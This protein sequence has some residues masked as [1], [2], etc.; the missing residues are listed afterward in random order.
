MRPGVAHLPIVGV[1]GSHGHDWKAYAAPLG[2]HLAARGVHLLTGGG[3]GTM[4][5][6][7]EAFCAVPDRRG[8]S[9]GILPAVPDRERGFAPMEGYPNPW[10]EIPV[11]TPLGK[12]DGGDDDL[13]TRNHVN[14]LTADAVVALPGSVGTHNEI[15]LARRFGRKIVLF[16]PR[17]EFAAYAGTLP[18]A[19]A[20][21]DVAAF[22]DGVLAPR[23]PADR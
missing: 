1:M 23:T 10:V 13:V 8:V 7:A 18:L 20:L 9:I 19:S 15:R 6:V 5:A 17:E 11:V 21:A 16:G 14:I 4:A 3:T 2:A 22:L 12:F